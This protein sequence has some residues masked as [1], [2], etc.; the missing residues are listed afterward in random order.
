MARVE[1]S[2]AHEESS[3]VLKRLVRIP[4]VVGLLFGL[5]AFA[6]VMAYW[7]VWASTAEL[8][9]EYERCYEDEVNLLDYCEPLD[10]PRQ[11]TRAEKYGEAAMAG[12]LW[13]AAAG[14]LMGSAAAAAWAATRS[15]FR[16]KEATTTAN[17]P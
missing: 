3:D 12:L 10:E 2:R 11:E 8:E 9:W 15:R 13:G 4:S 1:P 17:H 16:K 6:G 5:A 14:W 7:M